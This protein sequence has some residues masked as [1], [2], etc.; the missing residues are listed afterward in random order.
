[1]TIGFENVDQN[2]VS[3]VVGISPNTSE[4][5]R[6]WEFEEKDRHSDSSVSLNF[7]VTESREIRGGCR[8]I[9][10]LGQ[11]RMGSGDKYRDCLR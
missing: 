6:E 11:R 1:M 4:C 8:E 2:I 5:K 3:V 9:Q 7:S 10:S